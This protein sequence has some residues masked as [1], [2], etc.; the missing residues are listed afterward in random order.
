MIAVMTTTKRKMLVEVEKGM[1]KTTRNIHP[2]MH[3]TN[4]FAIPTIAF[5]EKSHS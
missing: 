3:T 5:K 4:F 1:M 2:M